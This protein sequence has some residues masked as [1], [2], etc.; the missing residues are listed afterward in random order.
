MSSKYPFGES[1]VVHRFKESIRNAHGQSV[2]VFHPD[3]LVSRVA[4]A[5]R[6]TAEPD[7]GISERVIYPMSL[8]FEP[9]F[10][11]SALDE[12]TVRGERFA[13]D[14]GVSGE[15]VNP[16]TGWAPGSEI[17]LKRVTG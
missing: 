12:V 8:Y 2:K 3:E 16:F 9:G 4:V 1:V 17:R 13:I 5:P 10:A 6:S 7:N 14:G 15:W 11:L